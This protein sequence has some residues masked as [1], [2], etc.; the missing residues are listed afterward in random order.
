[1]YQPLN[2]SYLQFSII[3][4][5]YQAQEYFKA[6][7]DSIVNQTFQEFEIIVVID[8]PHAQEELP[9]NYIKLLHDNRITIVEHNNNRGLAAARNT[10][11]RRA[12]G[13]W[14][15]CLDADDLLPINVLQFYQSLIHNT[16]Y[17]FFYGNSYLFGK[18]KGVNY[19]LPFDVYDL[20]KVK[21]PGGAGVLI[22]KSVF[23]KVLYDES[24]ILRKG[25]EDYE[26]WINVL[27]HEFRGCYVPETTYLYRRQGDTM[28]S[29]LMG[30]IYETTNYISIKH[31]EFLEKYN[32]YQVIKSKGY[33]LAASYY[34]SKN[35]FDEAIKLC[36]TALSIDSKNLQATQLLAKCKKARLMRVL[37]LR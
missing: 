13:E 6:C 20:L 30:T 16:A 1:L 36:Q 23:S 5:Y 25:N 9:H 35:N 34:L 10:G 12:K 27:R 18:E 17:S 24:D 26:F 33:F 2:K 7:L 3:I 15:I 4:P 29:N 11:I 21:C 31:K 14:I 22:H 37:R 19:F 28:V 32:L 8:G